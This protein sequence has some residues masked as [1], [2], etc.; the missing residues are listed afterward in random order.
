[1]KR[2]LLNLLTGLSL[3]LCVA[4][5]ALWVWSYWHTD[6]WSLARGRR[7]FL[8]SD[9]G[10]LRAGAETR[11]V[12]SGN[13]ALRG[14][15]FQA[16]YMAPAPYSDHWTF[17]AEVTRPSV[18]L[19]LVDWGAIPRGAMWI[20]GTYE[21]YLARAWTFP[22]A[23]LAA[24]FALPAAAR[25]AAWLLAFARFCHRRS[26]SLCHHCGYN[27]IGNTSGVYPECGSSSSPAGAA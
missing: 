23:A 13:P 2:R 3:L 11:F 7:Y 27:L 9:G 4:V 17:S 20:D 19:P 22:H 14:A 15:A 24:V 5:I 1:M 6:E 26:R 25:A 8:W 18:R 16:S 21:Y 12:D 10:R